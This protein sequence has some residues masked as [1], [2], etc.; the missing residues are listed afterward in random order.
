MSAQV[1]PVKEVCRQPWW[2]RGIERVLLSRDRV[3]SV[4]CNAD[5]QFWFRS[6]LDGLNLL[7]L[8]FTTADL[9]VPTVT[10]RAGAPVC[11][12]WGDGAYRYNVHLHLP[13]KHAYDTYGNDE[14]YPKHARMDVYV[15]DAM[16][17]ELDRLE[18]PE[19][20][21]IRGVD[22]MAEGI[23]DALTSSK[24]YTRYM[25]AQKL[26]E[27]GPAA[28]PALEA[29][30]ALASDASEY[31]FARYAAMEALANCSEPSGRQDE[32]VAV[33]LEG[34][35]AEAALT[36]AGALKGLTR[37]GMS[38]DDRVAPHMAAFLEQTTADLKDG[39][40]QARADAARLLGRLGEAGVPGV[41]ALLEAL[42]DPALDV[43]RAAVMSLGW[44]GRDDVA[45]L[46]ALQKA[47]D[48][49]D[50]NVQADARSAFASITVREPEPKPETVQAVEAFIA[51]H[52]ND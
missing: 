28:L 51:E 18:V 19:G 16:A 39:D 47:M 29:L 15:D 21:C 20:I 13:D 9:P 42:G 32:I 11:R 49:K 37:L 1:G 22:D 7:L 30:L 44:I 26:A 5:E 10:I 52:R 40:E 31:D 2:P 25:A 38:G 41:P 14:L 50:V 43:R 36:R 17:K 34:C 48:D 35:E 24:K 45:I 6:D 27:L 8:Q 33:L 4:W 3:Y 12:G 23:A 46:E